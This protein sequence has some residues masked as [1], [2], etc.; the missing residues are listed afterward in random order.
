MKLSI[1]AILCITGGAAAFIQQPTKRTS[2]AQAK[3]SI[4]SETNM[5]D[6]RSFVTKVRADLVMIADWL[7][8]HCLEVLGCFR[9][10]GHHAG[11]SLQLC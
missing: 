7:F 4:A 8:G 5:D 9:A 1:G 2:L 11:N 3:L 10:L 6:R